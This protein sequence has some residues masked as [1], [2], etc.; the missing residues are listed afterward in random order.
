MIHMSSLSSL[1]SK[2]SI[3]VERFVF[4]L[5]ITV[6]L[7]NFWSICAQPWRYLLKWRWLQ[8][9]SFRGRP[10]AA[11]EESCLQVVLNLS[12]S[13]P[14]QTE[15]SNGGRQA[16]RIRMNKAF[17][18]YVATKLLVLQ[19]S[20]H[21]GCNT[22]VGYKGATFPKT[23][24]W[25]RAAETQDTSLQILWAGHLHQRGQLHVCSWSSRAAG[26]WGVFQCQWWGL[27][28]KM[29]Q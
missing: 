18:K 25:S 29:D 7:V 24:L 27:F 19:N 16:Y 4:L 11:L 17:L 2:G 14:A 10:A 9:C 1:M 23:L 21:V 28:Q 20:F 26:Q 12:V 5:R 6:F 13:H 15:R 8:L 3:V 22:L